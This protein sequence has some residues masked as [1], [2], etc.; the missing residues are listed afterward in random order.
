MDEQIKY[1]QPRFKRW[2]KS[3]GWDGIVGRLPNASINIITK[4]VNAKKDDDCSWI[5]WANCDYVLSE[6]RRINEKMKRD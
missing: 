4:V 6:I 5:V 2:I 3:S 1:Y